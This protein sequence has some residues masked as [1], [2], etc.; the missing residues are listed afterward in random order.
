MGNH[1]RIE[2]GAARLVALKASRDAVV[3][4]VHAAGM[5][6]CEVFRCRKLRMRRRA[7]QHHCSLAPMAFAF[8][9]PVGF[10]A[11]VIAQ[12]AE[13]AGTLARHAAFP[14]T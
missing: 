5:H 11:Q 9:L 1:R 14:L 8:L 6:R 4:G 10:D 13:M 3:I 2:A 7:V 12:L